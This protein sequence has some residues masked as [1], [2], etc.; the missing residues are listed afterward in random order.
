M[1][2][3]KLVII[4]ALLAG[5][6][7]LSSACGGGG[8]TEVVAEPLLPQTQPEEVVKPKPAVVAI[9]ASTTGMFDNYYAILDITLRNDGA[10]GMVIVVGSVTQG[11]EITKN[12]LPVYIAH[13]ANQTVTLVFPLEWK[14]GDWTPKVETEIP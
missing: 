5:L 3:T 14:G 6:V 4:I 10:D 9:N 11:A 13:N 7:V 12:E 2:G 1:K 8:A